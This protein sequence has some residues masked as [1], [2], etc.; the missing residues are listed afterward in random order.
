VRVLGSAAAIFAIAFAPPPAVAAAPSEDSA[1]VVDANGTER[2]LPI[3]DAQKSGATIIDLSD[4]WTPYIFQELTGP[5]GQPL[6]SRYRSI[7][8]GLANDTSDADGQPLA[9][10]AHNYLELFGI[11]PT[12]RVLR[13][14]FLDDAAPD[15]CAQVAWDA[16][17]AVKSIPYREGKAAD[18]EAARLRAL[19]AKLEAQARKLKLASLAE[20]GAAD[21]KAAPDVDAVEKARLE[22][23]AFTAVEERLRCEGLLVDPAPPAG[24]KRR[25]PPRPKHTPGKFDDPFREALIRFQHK[26]MLYDA[27]AVRPDT[28]TALGRKPLENDH[29]ALVRALTERVVSAA[30]ILEDGSVE[31]PGKEPPTYLDANGQKQPVPN[32]VD[33]AV[34]ATLAQLQLDTPERALAFFQRHPEADFASLRAAVKLPPVP[35]YY[36]PS[37]DLSVEI[38]RGDVIYD[39]LYDEKTG[40]PTNQTRHHFPYLT[41]RVRHRG[42]LV[43]LARWRTTIGGWRSDL[44]SNGYEYFRYKGSDVG[45]RVWRNVVAGPVWIAPNSTPLRSLV[46]PKT[47][48]GRSQLV[49]NYDEVGP[50]YLSA[51]GLVAAYNV[52]PG[53]DGKPDWDNGVRVHGSSEILSI[54]NPNAYS[55]GCHRLMNHL[56]VRLFSWVL[57]H[58]DVILVGDRAL[59]FSRQFLWKEEV[60]EMR[61]PSRGFYFQLEPP[62]PVNVLEGNILG[63]T[64]KPITT[65]MPKPGVKY[66]PGPAPIPPDSP[67]ARAGGGGE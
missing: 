50:G 46:K 17:K 14:R 30:N 44:A 24:K 5:E 59:D 11:P 48:R 37:M 16:L 6:V 12:L 51:Y 13:Q 31:R 15:A 62:L 49:V 60:Y 3:A 25:A 47:V 65:Y 54:R 58:R 55:H 33:Q 64:K 23:L 8:L 26:H 4:S 10:G 20:L 21:P 52:V 22:A 53:K 56:A 9:A 19:R 34:K 67:E 35:E 41:L 66:P 29:L 40:K 28:L 1:I 18:K 38:D 39:P 43:P 57:R 2:A 45:P 61:L 36:G 27:A 7:Y 63:K 42:Q 32:L